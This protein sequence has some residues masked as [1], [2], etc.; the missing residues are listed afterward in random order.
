MTEAYYFR[1]QVGIGSESDCFL[2]LLNKILYT[3]DSEAVLK[4]EKSM[5]IIIIIRNSYSAIMPL[6]G[7]RGAGGQVGR[8]LSRK[9]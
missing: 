8:I 7:Y 5:I 3:S 1:S 6:G 9:Q 2:G 4:T